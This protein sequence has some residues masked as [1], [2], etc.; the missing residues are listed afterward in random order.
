MSA[1]RLLAMALVLMCVGVVVVL[2][3]AEQ[4]RLA[5]RTAELQARASR[6]ERTIRLQQSQIA[7]LRSPTLVQERADLLQIAVRPP[8]GV[9][10]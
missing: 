1:L 9:E 6:I 4:A 2:L 8:G 10:N 7:R 5:C 3:R